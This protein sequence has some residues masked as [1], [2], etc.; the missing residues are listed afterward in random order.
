M[1]VAEIMTDFRNL[2]HYIASIRANPSA[3]EYHEEGYVVLRQC[4]TEAQAVLA[5]PFNASAI[6]P[7]GNAEQEKTQLRQYVKAVQGMPKRT[8][9]SQG[10]LGSSSTQASAD[11]K[12]R[13][14]TSAQPLHCDGSTRGMLYSEGR[15]P[16]PY[17]DR[18]YSRSPTPCEL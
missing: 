6:S 1:R 18:L 3:E 9:L 2:Q 13:R 7:M 15:N 4:A 12:R 5:H 14:F 10:L 8:V 17:T 11:S 16:S